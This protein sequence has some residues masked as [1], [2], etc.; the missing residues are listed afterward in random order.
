MIKKYQDMRMRGQMIGT[1][2]EI[3]SRAVQTVRL[4]QEGL[5]EE[6]KSGDNDFTLNQAR[7]LDPEKHRYQ[8]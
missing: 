6:E 8:K 4:I 7:V 5:L 1:D 3:K 2:N